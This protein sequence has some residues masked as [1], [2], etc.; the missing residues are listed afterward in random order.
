MARIEDSE[1][2]NRR[3]ADGQ[4]VFIEIF[5]EGSAH[6]ILEILHEMRLAL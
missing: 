3:E 2:I 4:A 1:E 5:D 6:R